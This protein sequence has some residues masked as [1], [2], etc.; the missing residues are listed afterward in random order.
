MSNTIKQNGMS[1]MIFGA[2]HDYTLA[3]SGKGDVQFFSHPFVPK[4]SKN[5]AGQ[6][7]FLV[8]DENGNPIDAVKDDRAHCTFSPAIGAT[9]S[10]VGET[11]VSVHYH[12][13]YIHDEET[14]IVDKT[15]SQIITVVNHGSVSERVD[16]LDIYSDGYGF[17]RPL[18]TSGVE[19]K[20]YSLGQHNN[21]SKLSSIPWRATG[22]GLS[23]N[24]TGFFAS[25]NLED[26]S[27][28]KY[29]D[30]S[31][32][33]VII[34]PFGRTGDLDLS[35]I[36]DW[37]VSN[38]IVFRSFIDYSDIS[39]LKP[40]KKWNTSKFVD[41]EFA[42]SNFQGETLEG[43]EDWDVSN[44]EDMRQIF[45]HSNISDASAIA[46]WD[47]AKVQRLDYAFST[48][49]LT[50]TS[51]V[52]LWNVV[53]LENIEG[54]YKG[55]DYLTD[56]SGL[57]NWT[58]DIID[59]SEAFAICESLVDISGVRGLNVSNVTDFMAVFAF[60][61]HLIS[62]DGLEG[63]NVSNGTMFYRMFKGC[64]WISDISAIANWDMTSAERVDEMFNGD[65]YITTVDDLANWR[66][67]TQAVGNML[68]D[69]TACY[70]SKIDKPLWYNAYYYYDYEDHQY[71]NANVEDE[72]HPL[73]YPT[74]DANKARLWGVHGSNLHAFDAK[75]TNKPSWN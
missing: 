21:V 60:D 53:A 26:I 6:Y 55:C 48:T 24:Y 43:L 16:N 68:T 30:V 56:L 66:L 17:I 73:T 29:A 71:I 15:I 62:L 3:D 69:G 9:F 32:C 37:D 50:D 12:R 74:Y 27:E 4:N 51:A 47:V 40:L 22:L 23:W 5:Y 34:S 14:I 52:A 42:F 46:N 20:D 13:E 65:G 61:T 67:N 70:S 19:V 64:P 36:A 18:T 33:E 11:T 39:S 57:S 31:K 44:V 25:T 2:G 45:D 63:W 10:T 7:Y 1:F 38:V 54:I 58:A 35:P 28:F 49:N 59:I 41:M 75:W 8:P 72:D